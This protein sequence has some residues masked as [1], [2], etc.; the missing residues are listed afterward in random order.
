MKKKLRV[1]VLAS[2]GGTDLQSIIDAIDCDMVEAE[3]VVVV[4][5]Y[6]DAFCLKRAENHKIPFI[7]HGIG[8]WRTCQ[9]RFCFG[10]FN[11]D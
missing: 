2:G 5:D 1:G 9:L 11:N 8:A 3:V 6:K 10:G 7:F 4:S